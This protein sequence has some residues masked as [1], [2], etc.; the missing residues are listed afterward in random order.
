MGLFDDI[1]PPKAKRR[2]RPRN[3]DLPPETLAAQR[4][5]RLVEKLSAEQVEAKPTPQPSASL[6]AVPTT[7]E[8]ALGVLSDEERGFIRAYIGDP[9]RGAA[10]A[11]KAGCPGSKLTPSKRGVALLKRDRVQTAIKLGRETVAHQ[12]AEAT[13]YDRQAAF[14]EMGRVLERAMETDQ[15]TAAAR[16]AE[17]RA[18]LTG[19]LIDRQ[20]VKTS[21]FS[22]VF[23]GMPTAMPSLPVIDVTPTQAPPS[24]EPQGPG[25]PK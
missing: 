24:D 12:V 20:E 5:A 18:R 7:F 14:E 19:T 13:K 9:T 16:A 25:E 6:D 1:E 8:E 10:A 22:L 2:G 11:Y 3:A 15:M 4:G 23:E 17:L 21:S